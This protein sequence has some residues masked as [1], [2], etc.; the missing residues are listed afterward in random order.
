MICTF[1]LLVGTNHSFSQ[2]PAD[3]YCEGGVICK[4]GVGLDVIAETVIDASDKLVMPGI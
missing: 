3:V 2:A 4:V 1:A